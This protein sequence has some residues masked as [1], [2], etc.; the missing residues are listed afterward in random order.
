MI[1]NTNETTTK[2]FGHF[3]YKLKIKNNQ[4]FLVTKTV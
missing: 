3:K 4:D 2:N 1:K